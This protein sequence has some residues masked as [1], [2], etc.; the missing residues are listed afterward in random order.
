VSVA[1][2]RRPSDVNGVYGAAGAG[3]AVGPG[4]GVIPATLQCIIVGRP[5]VPGAAR[6]AND[7]A[8]LD[9]VKSD[10]AAVGVVLLFALPQTVRRFAPV[11]ALSRYQDAALVAFLSL[12]AKSRH[13]SGGPGRLC[14]KCFIASR[15]VSSTAENP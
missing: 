3:A 6:A 11:K 12:V 4:G 9:H 8:G 13:H 7:K 14:R 5:S 15:A 10:S 1:N 2:I